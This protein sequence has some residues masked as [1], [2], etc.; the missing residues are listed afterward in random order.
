MDFSSIPIRARLPTVM[1]QTRTSTVMDTQARKSSVKDKY[2]TIRI[3]T[4]NIGALTGRSA[5]LMEILKERNIDI[6]AIQETKWSGAKAKR[7]GGYNVYYNGQQHK[8]NGVAIA[9]SQKFNHTIKEVQ[10]ISDRI[11][12]VTMIFGKRAT[13]IICVYA[14]QA[15]SPSTTKDAF[16][17]LLDDVTSRCPTNEDLY[18]MGD[19]NGHIGASNDLFEDIQGRFAYG[20]RNED[21][22]RVLEY[23]KSLDLIIAN[24]LFQKRESH[25]ITY[26]SGERKTQIDYI[27]T[28]RSQRRDVIDCKVIPSVTVN[29]QHRPV[30]A[31]IRMP[32]N[33]PAF[34]PPRINRKLL[35]WNR[36]AYL[37]AI[38]RDHL[39]TLI[40]QATSN[41][42]E[43]DWKKLTKEVRDTARVIGFKKEC[44]YAPDRPAWFW[45]DD[46][47]DAVKAKKNA[48]KAWHLNPTNETRANYCEA[49][50]KAKQTIASA[51]KNKAD[52]LA[53]K[54]DTKE[55]EK[56]IYRLARW[57]SAATQDFVNTT[58][59]IKAS[60]GALLHD[61]SEIKNRWKEYYQE[62][63]NVE[64]PHPTLVNEPLIQG[65]IP[66]ISE[67]EVEVAIKK[68]R[69]GKA[70]G[71][72]DIPAEVW[73][74]F[75]GRS[76]LTQLFNKCIEEGRIP[77]DWR[78][79][80]TVPIY[81]K[82][83]D[84]AHCSNYRP[85]RLMCHTL[86]IFERVLEARLREIVDISE[87]QCGFRPEH[88]TTDAIHVARRMMEK[89][90]EWNK[91]L[92]LAFLDLEKA[93]DRVPR[94][95]IWEALR[96]QQV[97]EALVNAVQ[98]TYR[99]STT[100]IRTPVGDTPQFPVTV[101]V[102]QGSALSPLLFILCL[103]YATRKISK[104]P[105]L[106]LGYA[107]D[108]LLMDR[109]KNKLER[110]ANRWKKEL[111]A[112]GLKLNIN[113]TE[114]MCTTTVTSP[115]VVD[116]TPLTM[117][118]KFPYLGST[119]S[120]D[121]DAKADTTA[122]INA[123]WNKWRS[124]TGILC[125]KR[126]PIHL[127]SKI[128][129]SIV[130]PVAT[131][132][133][134]TKQ[135]TAVETRA[136]GVMEMKM[137]RWSLGH[138]RLERI[139]NETIRGRLKVQPIVNSL[140]ASRLRWYGHVQRR[141]PEAV[142]KSADRIVFAGKRPK[143]R[144]RLRWIDNLKKDMNAAGLS[145]ADSICRDRWK[146]LVKEAYPTNVGQQR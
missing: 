133:A 99:H 49:K 84:I 132:G 121:G 124:V 109:S 73:K 55:G 120:A 6:C 89:A 69:N 22:L 76:Y 107:D 85:I 91:P 21:G 125:D 126:M 18:I 3:A 129:T 13:N 108:V 11:M 29:S 17:E 14:P 94:Q 23:A 32:S 24:S 119:L 116:G 34:K 130:R 77:T 41:G 74:L 137:L 48:F 136:Y 5:E 146:A 96:H 25:L 58:T 43:E 134:E 45:N 66:R 141:P 30:I 52:S 7:I 128:Y 80:V 105:P 127:K 60:N 53:A 111:A 143:G 35:R 138:T 112:H 15:S 46:V 117:A 64:F 139:R 47:A 57:R 95:L 63:C 61:F 113:K 145:A 131:Y 68:M 65:P 114:Y 144:P 33:S 8:I 50:R 67:D 72:D 37:G 82:K 1:G 54:L 142:C 78:K 93:Y 9:I 92:H 102:H 110:R 26:Y 100:C 87:M 19:F 101:G 28:R 27:L 62:I 81:K 39:S 122:R 103:D 86:K 71:P 31:V 79:S 2:K 123:A 88:S 135:M 42:I 75:G 4:I 36:I 70:T 106:T 140:A 97:P 10:R 56:Q 115:I 51:I 12:L 40:H 16:W 83:G 44:K 118:T 90:R 59:F 98:L 104:K 38:E 20:T